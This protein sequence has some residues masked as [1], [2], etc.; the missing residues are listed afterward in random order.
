MTKALL[1]TGLQNIAR[2]YYTSESRLCKRRVIAIAIARATKVRQS[3]SAM[4]RAGQ[5]RASNRCQ[6]TLATS[7]LELPAQANVSRGQTRPTSTRARSHEGR[8][9]MHYYRLDGST[10][11][12]A[13][14]GQGCKHKPVLPHGERHKRTGGTEQI[15]Q[16]VARSAT[17]SCNRRT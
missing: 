17:S 9:D 16:I 4:S 14:H 6:Q 12:N 5:P 3:V 2:M 11:P 7:N 15:T 1:V 8:S 13:V 10:S